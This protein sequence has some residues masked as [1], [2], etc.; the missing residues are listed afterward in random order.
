[1][2]HGAGEVEHGA[3]AGGELAGEGGGGFVED[4]G[5]LGREIAGGA[6]GGQDGAERGGGGMAA[7]PFQQHRGFRRP[8]QSVER[9]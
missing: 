7:E 4:G 6:A 5:G 9:G 1:M 2:Q 3:L 8:Q